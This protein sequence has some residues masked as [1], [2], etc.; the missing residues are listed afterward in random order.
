[1]IVTEIYNG[2]GLGNQLVCYATTRAI[3]NDKGF[4]F[5]I[6]NPH[7]LKCLDFMDLDFGLPVIGGSSPYEGAPPTTLPNGITNYFRER[8]VRH[9]NGSDIR[10]DDPQLELILDNTKIDGVLQSEKNFINRKNEIKQ[11]FKVKPEFDCHD[12]SNDNI[13]V[14][15]FR[16]GEYANVPQFFL[17]KNYWDNA[18]NRML[19]INPNFQFIVIT[20]DVRRASQFFPNYKVLHYGIGVDYS[21]IKNAYY[22]ILSNSSFAYFPTFTSE[23]IKYII[24]PKYWGRHN[25]SDGYWSCGY[26]IY[27]NHNYIDRNN[28]IFTYDEC[29][30]EFEDYKKNNKNLWL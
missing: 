4:D 1:M 21:I 6:M 24:A 14:I 3:A 17:N 2:Q 9:P 13:C 28:N 12:Y 7:K 18:V 29:I 5:G 16:G 15:N 19:Q 30:L 25:I 20:D 11:W 27:H 22:L 8:D 26:N 23:T 10:L